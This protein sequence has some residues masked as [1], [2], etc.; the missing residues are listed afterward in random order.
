[1]PGAEE[2]KRLR[3]ALFGGHLYGCRTREND[4]GV[5]ENQRWSHR[6]ISHHRRGRDAM[7]IL[8]DDDRRFT[9]QQVQLT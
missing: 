3:L 7:G 4:G 8:V 6:F 9:D 2:L 5:T 1:M